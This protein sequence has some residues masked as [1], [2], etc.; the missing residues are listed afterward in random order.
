MESRVDEVK[1]L[2]RKIGFVPIF[3]LFAWPFRP[4]LRVYLLYDYKITGP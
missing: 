3:S 2:W 1:G 4:G